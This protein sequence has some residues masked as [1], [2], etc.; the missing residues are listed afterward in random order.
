MPQLRKSELL[1]VARQL[2]AGSSSV[3]DEA[4]LVLAEHLIL[5]ASARCLPRFAP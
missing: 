3:E 5:Q 4:K 2:W 1:A